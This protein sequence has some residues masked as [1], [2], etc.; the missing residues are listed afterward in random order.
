M[1]E[2][3]SGKTILLVDDSDLVAGVL[4]QFFSA[5]GYRVIRAENGAEG[6]RMAYAEIPDVIIMDVEMPLIQGYQASRLLKHR[7][8]VREIP[9]IMHTSRS[10]DRDQ[11]WAFDSG[12]DAFINK[13]FDNLEALAAKVAA[14]ANHPPPDRSVIREDADGVAGEGLF[15]IVGSLFDEQL[16]KSAVVNLLTAAGKRIGS[17]SAT[18]EG[19]FEVLDKVCEVHLAVIILKYGREPVAYIRPSDA[20][21]QADVEELYR[22]C[23]NDFYRHFPNLNLEKTRRIFMNLDH[24]VD[25]NKLRI[26]GRRISSYTT[27]DIRGKG[28]TVVGTLHL[29]NLTNNY[30]SDTIVAQV[31]TFTDYAGII[32]ENAILFNQISEMQHKLRNVFAKFVPKE[33]ID[34][35]V[36]RQSEETFLTGEKRELAVLFS[37]IRSFTTISEHN[38]AEDVVSFLNQYFN[39]MVRIIK[40]HGGTIDKF[41]GDAILAIFGAPKSYEDNALRAVRAAIEMIRAVSSVELGD[42]VLPPEGFQIGIGI[43]EGTAVVGNIGSSDQFDYT[44]IGDTVN[45]ASRLEGLTKYYKRPIIVSETVRERIADEIFLREVD[46]VKVKGKEAATAIYAVELDPEPFS[47]TFTDHYHKGLKLYKMGSWDTA[48]EYFNACAAAIPDDPVTAL[49]I[50]RCK[51]FRDRPPS[52]WDG[53]VVLDFK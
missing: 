49:F 32:M 18:A 38:P 33:I 29:G 27:V 17:L 11:Y 34:D 53:A 30:F 20:V 6:V 23:L 8:G 40:A 41:V 24:R 28:D 52:D 13:D 25:F 36:E 21:F 9:I 14:L 44:V 2:A 46:T 51:A 39:I 48:L 42:L 26:D 4:T 31:R 16:F 19:I 5:R 35:L 47:E 50:E 1:T 3:Q 10:E 7:R 45:L 22:V 37:D 15:E 12:A 43:H